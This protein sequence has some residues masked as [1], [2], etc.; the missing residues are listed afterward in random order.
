[1]VVSGAAVSTVQVY[2]A[3]LAS[4]LPAESVARTRKVW[5]PSASAL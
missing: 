5:D 2:V 4:V 1:M 3:G